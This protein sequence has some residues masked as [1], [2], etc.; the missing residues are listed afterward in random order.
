MGNNKILLFCSCS[1]LRG[2]WSSCHPSPHHHY[3]RGTG[4]DAAENSHT[5]AAARVLP[6]SVGRCSICLEVADSC[7]TTRSCSR[8]NDTD[9]VR[10]IPVATA[11]VAAAAAVKPVDTSCF[12]N[13]G[14]QC[15]GSKV[16]YK[17]KK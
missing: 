5:L 7:K 10:C 8:P 3:P 4:G 13:R 6:P 2:R 9:G 11:V 17:Q 16:S 12:K 14:G 15:G 1:L